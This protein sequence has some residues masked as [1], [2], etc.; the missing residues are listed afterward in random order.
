MWVCHL[1]VRVLHGQCFATLSNINV[2]WTCVDRQLYPCGTAGAV[3]YGYLLG[4]RGY[5]RFPCPISETLSNINVPVVY[6][7]LPGFTRSPPGL[8]VQWSLSDGF[9]LAGPRRTRFAFEPCKTYFLILPLAFDREHVSWF[10]LGFGKKKSM[11]ND[12]ARMHDAALYRMWYQPRV[13]VRCMFV[14]IF[15]TRFPV[16]G[17]RMYVTVQIRVRCCFRP[18]F[19]LFF[20]FFWERFVSLRWFY[21]RFVSICIDFVSIFVVS[22]RGQMQ[23]VIIIRYSY[24]IRYSFPFAQNIRFKVRSP[25]GAPFQATGSR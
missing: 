21:H 12:A 25:S 18:V 15:I 9:D 5:S 1:P 8:L 24:C 20:W 4:P 13:S 7:V 23:A 17:F 22:V 3:P 11:Q 19:D 6:H 14:A 10:W 16:R 2:L